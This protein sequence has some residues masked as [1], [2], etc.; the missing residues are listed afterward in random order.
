[1][2]E[3][4]SLDHLDHDRVELNPRFTSQQLSS[5]LISHPDGR[6]LH[7]IDPP[8]PE[9]RV[10]TAADFAPVAMKSPFTNSL[11]VGLVVPMPTLPVPSW[12]IWAFP[13]SL[14]PPIVR[15][16][17]TFCADFLDKT[18]YRPAIF[19]EVYFIDQDRNSWLS[20]SPDEPIFTLNMVDSPREINGAWRWDDRWFEMNRRF[21]L[22]AVA[23][24]HTGKECRGRPILNQTKELQRT[25]QVL[26]QAFGKDWHKFVA[27]VQRQDPDGRFRSNFFTSLG[28]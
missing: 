21:N 11:A 26:P 6:G 15:D 13:R 17:L 10:A 24:D 2:N 19:T 5:A 16:Y 18:G 1:M 23:K 14:W 22:W 12:I 20:F 3:Q 28:V 4:F 9:G 8:G 7:R 27:R 25:P